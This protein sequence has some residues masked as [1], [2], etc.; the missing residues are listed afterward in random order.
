MK[1]DANLTRLSLQIVRGAAVGVRWW[2][3]AHGAG[4]MRRRARQHA[5]LRQDTR[6]PQSAPCSRKAAFTAD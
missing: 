3:S 4:L 2:R 1:S 6:A 5:R